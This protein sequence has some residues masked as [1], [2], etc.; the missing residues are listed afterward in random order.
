MPG[1]GN[2]RSDPAP[3]ALTTPR[4]DG[5]PFQQRS[6]HPRRHQQRKNLPSKRLGRAPGRGDEQFSPRWRPAWQPPELFAVVHSHHHG[7]RQM[8]GG[9]PRPA[10][11]RA[12]GLGLCDELRARQRPATGRGLSAARPATGPE[13]RK[14]RGGLRRPVRGW[15]RGVRPKP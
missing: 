6:L 5:Y 1:C 3:S 7:R 13:V 14:K 10:R 8:R 4:S 9:A 15:V 11:P 12:H 2:L